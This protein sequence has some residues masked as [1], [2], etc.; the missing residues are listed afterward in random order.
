MLDHDVPKDVAR[1]L[2]REGHTALSLAAVLPPTS[3]DSEVLNYAATHYL[4]LITCNRDDFLSL[5]NNQA[6][7]G[8]IILIRHRTRQMEYACLLS[9]LRNAGEQGIRENVNFA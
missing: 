3:S 9:L 7:P 8:L 2:E 6:H 5:T 4:V 1:I